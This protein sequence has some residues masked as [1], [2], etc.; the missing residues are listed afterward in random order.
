[1]IHGVE[2]VAVSGVLL[3]ERREKTS[4]P[5]LDRQRRGGHES[6]LDMNALGVRKPEEDVAAEGGIDGRLQRQLD[7]ANSEPCAVFLRA[8]VG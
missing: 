5:D 8:A 4:Q 2:I 3:A 6:L 1:M 7:F